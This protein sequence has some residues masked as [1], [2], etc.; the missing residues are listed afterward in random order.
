MML[1][2]PVFHFI[3][4]LSR[5]IEGCVPTLTALLG[6]AGIEKSL[7]LTSLVLDSEAL[8]SSTMDKRCINSSGEVLKRFKC[9]KT[10]I[11]KI[12]LMC[13]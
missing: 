10:L 4:T 1:G 7:P 11:L 8:F 6:G 13:H 3:L 9:F 2:H 5:I 12:K